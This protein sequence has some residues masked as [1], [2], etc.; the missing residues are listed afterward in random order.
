MTEEAAK[1]ES[2]DI[3]ATDP[4]RRDLVQIQ[5]TTFKDD[6]LVDRPQAIA[7]R[8]NGSAGDSGWVRSDWRG[9]RADEKRLCASVSGCVGI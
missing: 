3:V 7:V 4:R 5:E 2:H 1:G 9:C 8:K 6:R